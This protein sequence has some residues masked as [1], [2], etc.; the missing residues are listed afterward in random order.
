MHKP[1]FH[2]SKRPLA[3]LTTAFAHI[4]RYYQHANP[5]NTF[6]LPHHSANASLCLRVPTCSHQRRVLYVHC[7]SRKL[8]QLD[9]HLR[10]RNGRQCSCQETRRTSTAHSGYMLFEG[11]ACVDRSTRFSQRDRQDISG[12]RSLWKIIVWRYKWRPSVTHI[13]VGALGFLSACLVYTHSS[14]VSVLVLRIL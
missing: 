12:L 11:R 10:S 14:S 8:Y 2:N 6:R 1:E 7:T 4:S 13:S 5:A 3:R 9:R